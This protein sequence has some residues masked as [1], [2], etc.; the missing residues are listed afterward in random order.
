MLMISREFHFSMERVMAH[1]REIESEPP[2]NSVPPESKVAVSSR[3]SLLPDPDPR[4]IA[5]L[6]GTEPRGWEEKRQA[7]KK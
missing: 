2:K 3:Y 4:L 5:Y 7:K 1:R 6:P